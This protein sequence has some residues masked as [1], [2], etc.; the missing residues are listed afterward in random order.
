[1]IVVV[2][3]VTVIILT[4]N[5]PAITGQHCATRV[6]EPTNIHDVT[7]DA[8]TTGNCVCGKTP[9]LLSLNIEVSHLFNN[10]NCFVLFPEQ[11]LQS[12]RTI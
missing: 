5:H 8:T 1:M 3:V 9:P 7:A 6:I 4:M 10:T 11:S 12:N 2:V